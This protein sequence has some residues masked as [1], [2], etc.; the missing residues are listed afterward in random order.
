[1]WYSAGRIFIESLRIDSLMIYSF[2]IAQDCFSCFILNRV[3]YICWKK[4]VLDLKIDTK[5]GNNWWN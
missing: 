2:K 5:K 4:E 1:M 3:N